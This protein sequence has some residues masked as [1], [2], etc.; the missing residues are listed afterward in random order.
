[1]PLLLFFFTSMH[2]LAQQLLTALTPS[3]EKR[4]RLIPNQ[5]PSQLV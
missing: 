5:S 4:W 2:F 3:C 1:M